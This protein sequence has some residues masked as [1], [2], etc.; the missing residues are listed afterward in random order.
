MAQPIVNPELPFVGEVPSGLQ[1]GKMIRFQGVTHPDS[2]RFNIN[3]A[4]GPT[5]KP[6]DD[7]ALHLSVRLNQ[8]YIA[9]NSY[10]NGS[11]DD[12][13]GS[14]KLPIGQAQ[15]FEIIILVDP[16]HYKIAV[17]GQHFCE[18][19]HRIPYDQ[20]TH[21]LIDGDVSITLISFEGIALADDLT[22]SQ[23]SQVNAEGPQFAPPAGQ[24]GPPP[25]AYGPPPG[26]YGAPPPNF[27][28]YGPPPQ[29]QQSQFGGIFEQAQDILAGAIRTG[30]AEKLLS[31]I[32]HSSGQGQ[33]QPQGYAPQNAKYG[34]YPD[35]PTQDTTPRQAQDGALSNLIAG[36]GGT[37]TSGPA[38]NIP[39]NTPGPFESLLSGLLSGKKGE[40]ASQGAEPQAHP[41][42]L[43]GFLTNLL[44]G[45]GQNPAQTG[46]VPQNPQ[47]AAPPT[48]PDALQ[49]FLTNLLGGSGQNPAQSGNVPQNPQGAAPQTQPDALQ[50]FLTN[51]LGGSHNN[52]SQAGDASQQSIGGGVDALSGIFQNLL[53]GKKD[54]NTDATNSQPQANSDVLSG[55]LSNLVDPKTVQKEGEAGVPNAGVPPAGAP[56]PAVLAGIPSGEGA[57]AGSPADKQTHPN[58]ELLNNLLQ[59]LLNKGGQQSDK[60][61][62]D[63]QQTPR[64]QGSDEQYGQYP[65]PPQQ[66]QK[67]PMESLLSGILGG[68][69]QQQQQ[70]SQGGLGS[71][72][73][74]LGSLAGSLLHKP[75]QNQGH[76]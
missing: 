34:I 35:L 55:I 45:G 63:P 36:S 28:G 56:N 12:E 44:G 38:P 67:G 37:V 69:G 32:L 15:S 1:P 59:G 40:Q 54:Q 64:P 9:R 49:G 20:V 10:K 14:G 65:H 74:I 53:S 13:Q 24:Y 23:A 47:A 17:N 58:A 27:G 50:G 72:G 61:Q 8:G 21:L 42:V 43:Q 4:T 33:Q 18:F 68:G 26:A 19:P 3:L 25:G 60:T 57:A 70:Q 11:W 73:G 30:A 6:R 52:P 51:L 41:D 48:Q 2:D 29:E 76:Y 22:S 5:A 39:Q 31:S 66:E 7:T 75:D 62:P 46:N 16:H 71:M